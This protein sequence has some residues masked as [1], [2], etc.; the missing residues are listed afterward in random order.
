MFQ[1]ANARLER[2]LSESKNGAVLS[3]SAGKKRKPREAGKRAARRARAVSQAKRGQRTRCENV[4]KNE[5]GR[6]WDTLLGATNDKLN[7][8]IAKGGTCL[9]RSGVRSHFGT[10]LTCKASQFQ[11][12][13]TGRNK[14]LK[15][16]AAAF[17]LRYC[18]NLGRADMQGYRE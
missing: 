10:L 4:E 18:R 15:C 16:L 9:L 6:V 12:R 13:C 3:V 17:A 14:V 11:G 1:C 8:R 7:R 2:M 5:Q